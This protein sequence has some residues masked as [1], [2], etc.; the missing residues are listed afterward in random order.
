MKTLTWIEKL[1]PILLLMVF[2]Q[3]LYCGEALLALKGGMSSIVV[4]LV[5]LLESVI[6]IIYLVWFL[7]PIWKMGIEHDFKGAV[8]IFTHLIVIAV[9]VAVGEY[10]IAMN[11]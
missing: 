5:R 10:F 4:L 11:V 1:S 8:K 3:V 9:I 6:V 7:R 2:P